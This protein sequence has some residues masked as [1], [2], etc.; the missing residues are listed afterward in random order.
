M[1]WRVWDFCA[2]TLNVFALIFMIASRAPTLISE[3]GLFGIKFNINAG[4]IVAFSIP[5]LLLGIVILEV[6][7]TDGISQLFP[8]RNS[9]NVLRLFVY[10]PA[11][12]MLFMLVQFSQNFAPTIDDCNQF[13]WSDMYFS[14]SLFDKKPDYC[15]SLLEKQQEM[16]P[17][18]YA[19]VQSWLY[20]LLCGFGLY[21]AV[22]LDKLLRL[23]N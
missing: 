18:V 14:F 10:F 16:M 9:P 23:E 22:T 7:R 3:F 15:F 5:L 20:V 12:A 11:L 2:V 6:L 13:G 8:Y 4:Y 17:H 21:K 19:P 1:N